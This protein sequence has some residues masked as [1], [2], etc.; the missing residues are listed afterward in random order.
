MWQLALPLVV[1]ACGD[2]SA[3]VVVVGLLVVLW[4]MKQ[5]PR[6]GPSI[7]YGPH[8]PSSLSARVTESVQEEETEK[9]EEKVPNPRKAQSDLT[10][11]EMGSLRVPQTHIVGF[12]W[13]PSSESRSRLLERQRQE[14]ARH[15][16]HQYE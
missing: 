8:M 16:L 12:R 13:Q 1:C 11:G 10:E 9:E 6:P 14:L 3:V 4:V 15:K 2:D 5:T 7:P